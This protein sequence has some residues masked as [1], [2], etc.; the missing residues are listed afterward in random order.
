LAQRLCPL[1]FQHC[2][3]QL[4]TLHVYR[5]SI[6]ALRIVSNDIAK[7][8]AGVSRIS[9]QLE[10]PQVVTN[11]EPVQARARRAPASAV[12]AASLNAF[13]WV[14]I[15]ATGSPLAGAHGVAQR[16]YSQ[17]GVLRS[18]VADV[19]SSESS[20]FATSLN[21]GAFSTSCHVIRDFPGRAPPLDVSAR[22][23]CR[24]RPRPRCGVECRS[25]E[26][27]R[28]V[29]AGRTRSQSARGRFHRCHLGP[30][31]RSPD[32]LSG[33]HIPRERSR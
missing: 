20:V 4:P 15:V 6:R 3:S 17:S 31:G 30:D 8:N 18:A 10:D 7:R 29:A 2:L 1:L 26:A 25:V 27:P 21:I 33:R 16:F 28:Q 14:C 22:A 12:F 19:Q 13:V 11:L 23:R 5:P 24:P 32:G 9:L